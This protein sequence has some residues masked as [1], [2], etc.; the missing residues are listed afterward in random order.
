MRLRLS[1][2]NARSAQLV[3]AI[4]A[5]SAWSVGPA[6]AGPVPSVSVHRV[7]ADSPFEPGACASDVDGALSP[8]GFDNAH[9]FEIA[10]TF[11]VS[12]HGLVAAWTQD[13]GAVD[14][15]G[16]VAAH[17]A[18]GGSTWTQNVP[19]ALTICEQGGNAVRVITSR[20]VVDGKGTTFLST[21]AGEPDARGAVTVSTSPDGGSTWSE[22]Q[23]VSPALGLLGPN[24]YPT[25][26]PD[27]ADPHAVAITWDMPF[28]PS[29]WFA[30]TS[31]DGATWTTPVPIEVPAPG[32]IILGGSLVT[33]PDGTLV[34]V[35]S[36]TE[37]T[38][39][40]GGPDIGGRGVV[41][42][43]ARSTDHGSTWSVATI[44][45]L[46]RRGDNQEPVDPAVGPDGAVYV[47][48]SDIDPATGGRSWTV[49]RSPDGASW[50]PLANVPLRDDSFLDYLSQHVAVTSDGTIGALYDDHRN[51]VPH[52]DVLTTDVW[53]TYSHDGG[54][55][56]N[57]LHVAGPFDLNAIPLGYLGDYQEMHAV[58][59]AF[60]AVVVLGPCT[61]QSSASCPDATE[62]PG[63]VYFARI[64]F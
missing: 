33:L 54:A 57:D 60:E 32:L 56:W 43:A 44:A 24:D 58:G 39:A 49:Y 6:H 27:P 40:L 35:V 20:L 2:R 31:D 30:R 10:P 28:V 17:S 55:T 12:P 15:L 8:F 13:G 26:S 50:S 52:D 36:E 25:M 47:L 7:S 29:T 11:A 9:G 4:A 45:E 48:L 3:L 18:D 21:V 14:G 42:R 38:V 51:D 53:L 64:S 22:P 19:P 41:V 59:D 63:D 62:G 16:I 46:S 61:Q 34:D 37:P 5:V 1:I 23:P